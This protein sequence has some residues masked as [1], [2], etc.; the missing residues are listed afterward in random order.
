M[1]DFDHIDASERGLIN[2]LV[3]L[4]IVGQQQVTEALEYQCR[5]PRP[6]K[7]EEILVDME[8]LTKAALEQAK[9][10]MGHDEP[11]A[12]PSRR[13]Q[14]QGRLD[15]QSESTAIPDR[16]ARSSSGPLNLGALFAD[17]EPEDHEA[18]S[19][20]Q[21]SLQQD[22]QAPPLETGFQLLDSP[23]EEDAFEALDAPLHQE[24]FRETPAPLPEE[25]PVPKARPIPEMPV[26]PVA[27]G[28]QATGAFA[29]RNMPR[30]A[31]SWSVSTPTAKPLAPLAP[32]PAAISASLSTAPGSTD[33]LPRPQLGE[34]LI[35]NCDLEEWQLTHALCIQRAAPMTTPKLGTLL[36]KLGYVQPQAVEKA[37]GMQKSS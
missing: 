14:L 20:L 27:T 10:L 8:Y 17:P 26:Q 23:P 18:L 6:Q 32:K 5:L 33:A 4:N 9:I 24:A 22:L 36:V 37:L 7:L 29:Q 11:T 19:P 21:A 16:R 35:K 3:K 28:F 25:P 31:S 13:N 30:N 15:E 12:Q 1:G 2:L 34:I